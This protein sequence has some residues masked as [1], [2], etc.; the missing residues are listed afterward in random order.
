MFT[1][2]KVREDLAASDYKDPGPYKFPA[3]SVAYE[4]NGD[5]GA[6]PRQS[7]PAASAPHKHH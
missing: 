3:G 1:V 5:T 4:F 2:M 7:E 6:A